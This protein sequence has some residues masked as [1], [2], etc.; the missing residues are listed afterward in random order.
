MARRFLHHAQ[1]IGAAG[2]ITLPFQEVIETQAA[3]ALPVT[4]G[5]G[6]ARTGPFRYRELMSFE[7]AYTDVSGSFSV[8]DSAH[9]TRASAVLEGVNILNVITADRI[10]ARVSSRHDDPGRQPSIQP[11]G[12]AFH[13]LRVGGRLVELDLAID[14]FCEFDTAEALENAFKGDA[15]MRPHLSAEGAPPVSN[16]VVVASLVRDVMGLAPGIRCAGGVIDLPQIGRVYLGEIVITP[17]SRRITMLR[18]EMGCPEEGFMVMGEVE[19]NG[20]FW[21]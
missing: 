9:F 2:R 19:G 15:R 1:A 12:C 7:A 21:P 4:G 8:K 16:G 6:S 17:Q 10:V 3:C 14:T 20:R 11:F 5:Y 18:I 13:N